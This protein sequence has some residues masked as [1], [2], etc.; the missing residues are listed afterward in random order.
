MHFVS[1]HS[2]RAYSNENVHSAG[3]TKEM[4]DDKQAARGRSLKK[5][6]RGMYTS[7]LNVGREKKQKK[8]EIKANRLLPKNAV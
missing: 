1:F 8:L 7:C 4:M 6:L 5:A 3:S 2:V